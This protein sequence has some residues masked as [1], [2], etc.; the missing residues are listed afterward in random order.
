M[1]IMFIRPQRC[2]TIC[3]FDHSDV[4]RSC[5]FD[6]SYPVHVHSYEAIFNDHVHSTTASFS[7]HVLS[8]TSIFDQLSSSTPTEYR[9]D[10]SSIDEMSWNCYV[11]I[12]SHCVVGDGGGG[13]GGGVWRRG[14]VGR[15]VCVGGR[16][17]GLSPQLFLPQQSRFPC[18]CHLGFPYCFSAETKINAFGMRPC[19][20]A[21][22]LQ[23][24]DW[25]KPIFTA[26]MFYFLS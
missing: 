7:E 12:A 13:G 17:G 24:F 26:G 23:R 19:R 3:S 18:P 20:R 9:F 4:R 15:K 6:H 16:G 25:F 5:L 22:R 14:A 21:L 1:L 10:K 8:A 11:L 2:Q